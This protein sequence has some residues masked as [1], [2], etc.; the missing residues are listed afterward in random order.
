[1][2]VALSSNPAATTSLR[3]FGTTVYPVLQVSFEGDT[4]SRRS[5]LHG[6]YARGSKIPQTGGKCVTCRGLH[7]S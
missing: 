7:H 3:N 6:V 2:Q 1:M 4:K 5:V